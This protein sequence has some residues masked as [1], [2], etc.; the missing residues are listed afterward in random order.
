MSY[1]SSRCIK[2]FKQSCSKHCR[3]LTEDNIQKLV[4]LGFAEQNK[5]NSKLKI[6]D[7]CRLKL[8]NCTQLSSSD[9][10]SSSDEHVTSDTEMNVPSQESLVTVPSMTSVNTTDSEIGECS[11]SVNIEIFNKSISSILTSPI[12]RKKMNSINYVKR[13]YEEVNKKIRRE[14]FKL[15]TID[16]IDR[17]K[18]NEFDEM[19]AQIKDKFS[20]D[21]ITRNEKLQLLSILPRSWTVQ[22]IMD[23]FN[24]SRYLATQAK[25]SLEGTSKSRT[26]FGLSNVAKEI[27]VNFYEDD[28]TSRVMPGQ[29][30]YVSVMRDG[31]R[32][33][34]QKRLMMTT[35]RESFNRFTELHSGVQIGFSSFAKLR[36]KNC[37]LLTS[38]GTHNVCVC[39]IHENVN[40]I[41]HSLKKYNLLHDLIFF[42]D[43]LLCETKTVDC[44]LR[45]CE[46]CS[47]STT[48]ERSLLSEIEENGIDELQFEQWV[49]TDRCDI[50]TFLKQPDE[51]VSYFTRKLEKLIPHDFI[52][53]EQATFLNNTK[54]N[55]IEGEFVVICDF[56]ENYTFILQDEVQSHHWNA[57]QAT[58]HPFVIYYRQDGKVNHLS[59]VVISEDL[60]HDSVSV[61]LFISKMIDFLRL[62]HKLTVNK[63]YF[64]SDGAASQYKNRKNFSTLWQFKIKYDIEVEWHFFATSHG[65]GPCDAIGGTLKR[66]ATRA[67]LAKEREHPIKN[68]K[69]L[70][71][72]AQNRKEEQLTQ[73]FFCYSTT[74]E[75]DIIA[76]ELNQLF[77]SAKTVQ[78]TQKY[79]SFIPISE[80]QIEVRQ[81]SS[82]DDNKKVVD[83]IKK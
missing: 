48:F 47:D 66:M 44:T 17:D 16:E 52:K 62:D 41:I 12:D 7:S 8:S 64:M 14:I 25:Q 38:S 74:E 75:Y 53:K 9:D 69:E 36:P 20:K 70:Y 29:R 32:L 79:H 4:L 78:G 21:G 51:F 46:K 82:C 19:I 11:Q 6:C 31:K 1:I 23:T 65:K 60:R 37:K 24:T 59:F 68:A 61:N 67:S 43:S 18:V 40:L 83:I 80:T 3:N 10:S 81:F 45:C 71:D 34:I 13:K 57:Q 26:S 50:E 30:D 2:V 72:W 39:T 33:A 55:L 77:S 35:L 58:L 73:I 5:L 49:T 63:I 42:T 27:V 54:N 76:Q 22:K 28:E 15:N 56:S